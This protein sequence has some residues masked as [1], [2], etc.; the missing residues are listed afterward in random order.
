MNVSLNKIGKVTDFIISIFLNLVTP[1]IY[2]REILKAF[3]QIGWMS[4]PDI[5]VKITAFIMSGRTGVPLF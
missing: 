1:P 2:G 4:L 3:Y 5:V